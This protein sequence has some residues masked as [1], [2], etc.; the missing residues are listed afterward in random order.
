MEEQCLYIRAHIS[1]DYF[2]SIQYNFPREE[3]SLM[4]IKRLNLEKIKGLDLTTMILI[5]L[6][7]F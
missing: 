4:I 1:K 2:K 7:N 3:I 5:I 6:Q